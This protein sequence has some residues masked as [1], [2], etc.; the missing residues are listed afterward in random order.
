M[1]SMRSLLDSEYVTSQGSARVCYRSE[2]E[3]DGFNYSS[4]ESLSSAPDLTTVSV[5]SGSHVKYVQDA[6]LHIAAKH[7]PLASCPSCSM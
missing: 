2:P 4:K 7:E 1:C 6:F 5:R 3:P